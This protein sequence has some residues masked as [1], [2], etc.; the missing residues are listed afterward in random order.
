MLIRSMKEI[1]NEKYA[2]KVLVQN[3]PDQSILKMDGYI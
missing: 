3:I 2:F 1:P